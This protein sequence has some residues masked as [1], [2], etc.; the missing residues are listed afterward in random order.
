M[1]KHIA[2]VPKQED[3]TNLVRRARQ[4]DEA[5]FHDIYRLHVR[6]VA[7]TAYRL[8]GRED[9]VD[10]VI[11]ETFLE[12]YRALDNLQDPQRL[13]AWL[14][15][16]A[17][18]KAYRKLNQR[19]RTRQLADALAKEESS[20]GKSRDEILT[21]T[22]YQALD[23]LDPKLRVPWILRHIEGHTINEVAELCQTSLATVKRRLKKAQ[24]RLQRRLSHG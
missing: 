11:Q 1:V 23:G 12:A 6:S 22:L 21:L 2:S 19:R 7:G 24:S 10:D 16:I 17:V 13:R 9:E 4:G 20:S 18:H 15:T 8:L 3:G 5:A 14:R